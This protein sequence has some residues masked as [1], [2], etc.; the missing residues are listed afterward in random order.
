MFKDDNDLLKKI[1]Y[2]LKHEKER[3]EI[4]ENSYKKAIKNHNVLKEFKE[5]F[6]TILENLETFSQKFPQIKEKSITLKKEYFEKSNK[7]I[8]ESLKKFD[9]ISFSDGNSIPLKHKEYLQAYSLNKTK[10]S[11]SC[12]D[13]YVYDKIL[14]NYLTTN[15]FRAFPIL[16]ADKFN[17]AISLN[18]IMVSKDYF[19]KNLNK[20]R[21]FFNGNKIDIINEKNTAFISIPLVKI[22]KINKMD[23]ETFSIFFHQKNFIFD[24]NLL[25][26]QKRLFASHYFYR[27]IYLLLK[28]KVFRDFFIKF[29]KERLNKR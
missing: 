23:L 13:C 22:N 24:I 9:Y 16:K 15:V 12:C 8:E 4:A 5:V 1:N 7:E 25:L 6:K 14:G 11:I 17:Q 19:I 28:K 29:V 21:E 27:L 10:K 3:E 26:K 20:F 2:Y 18:Q